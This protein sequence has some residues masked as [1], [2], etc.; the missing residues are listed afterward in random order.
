MNDIATAWGA[1]TLGG[2]SPRNQK[3]A[4]CS[5]TLMLYLDI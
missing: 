2:G 1:H 3:K 4:L 5:G